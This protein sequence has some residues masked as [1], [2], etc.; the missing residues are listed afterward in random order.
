MKAD[1]PVSLLAMMLRTA[2]FAVT[3]KWKLGSFEIHLE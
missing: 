2:R 1:E 3:F